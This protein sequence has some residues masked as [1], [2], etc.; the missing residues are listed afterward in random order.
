[1]RHHLSHM[2]R[3]RQL[4][5][6][7]FFLAT[8]SS[9]AFAQTNILTY[10]NDNART[11]QNLSEAILTPQNVNSSSFGKLFTVAMDGKVDAEPLYMSGVPVP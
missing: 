9:A 1:M 6:G 3:Y 4:S 8:H 11:G 5:A 2:L 7:I 10:H